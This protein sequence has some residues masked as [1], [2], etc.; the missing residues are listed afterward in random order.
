MSRYSFPYPASREAITIPVSDSVVLRQP[1]PEDAEELHALVDANRDFLRQWLPWLDASRDISATRAFIENA[2][3]EAEAGTGLDLTIW[4]DGRIA[5]VTGYNSI[6]GANRTGVIGYWLGA[7]YNGRG[8]MTAS[9]RALTAHGFTT[10]D[11]NRQHISAATGN[12]RSRAVAE[13]AGY[14]VEG[15]RRE[16]EW[17]YDHY[18]DLVDHGL[19][20]AE[21]LASL[22]QLP[23]TCGLPS[24][25][26]TRTFQ[27][28]DIDAAL[29]LWHATE[30]VGVSPEETPAMLAD[31]LA[32][33]PG[34]SRVAVDAEGRLVG[35][36][37]GGHDGRRALLYHLAVVPEARG[38]G[39]GRKLVREA[40]DRLAEAGIAKASILVY[41]NNASG[42]AFWAKLG[43]K[44]R[45]DL[46]LLQHALTPPS[47]CD[48]GC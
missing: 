47:G 11:L 3:R 5:G 42:H 40:L 45:K 24:G 33:N 37:L 4:V 17:L 29:N 43:W 36:I 1:L 39:V 38:H 9:V 18:V 12:L 13:R 8:I 35:T 30:G 22:R 6:H 19:T 7:A 27:T 26:S 28:G 21:W 44:A 14:R 23:T 41:A 15:V 31:Y 32:R 46:V 16:A 25:L 20:R 10:L 2:L 48:A 34:F